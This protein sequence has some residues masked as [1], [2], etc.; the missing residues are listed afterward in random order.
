[1]TPPQTIGF[2]SNLSHTIIKEQHENEE[3][4]DP[5]GEAASDSGVSA[6][7]EELA[8]MGAPWAKEGLLQRKHYMDG[9]SRRAKDKHWGQVFVVI[10]KG[11]FRMFKFGGTSK[12][13]TRGA[14][15]LGGGN[16]LVS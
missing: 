10:S 1:M 5:Q 8:L 4:D 11:D 12:G 6:T 14:G 3:E 16:W 9:Q 13:S 2:A 7:D 15:G